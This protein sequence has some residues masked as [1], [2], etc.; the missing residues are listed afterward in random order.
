MISHLYQSLCLL[1]AYSKLLLNSNSHNMKKYFTKLGI[2]VL[3]LLLTSTLAMAQFTVSGTVTN[4]AGEA[5]IGCTVLIKNTVQGTVTDLDGKYTVELPDESATLLF[6]SVGMQSVEQEVTAETTTLDIVLPESNNRLEEVVVSGLATSV[7]RANLANSVASISAKE[8]TGIAPAA[9]T[10]GA[11]YGKFKG[12]V[13]NSNSGAPGGGM[14][15][16]LRG[17]TSIF[18]NAQPLYIVD[19]VYV[20]NSSVSAGLN[21]VSS[22]SGGG[23]QSNQDNPSNR[24]A[25]IDPGDIE[26]IEILKGASAAAMYGS[27][28]AAGVVII[29]TKK[30]KAGQT[31]VKLS[32]SIGVTSQLRKLGIREWDAAEVGEVFGTEDSL[33]FLQG[34][35]NFEDELYGNKGILSDTR[36]SVTGGNEQTSFYAGGSYKNDEGIVK[37]TGYEK[38]SIRL[39]IAHKLTD[40]LKLDATSNYIHSSADRG[41]FNNDNSGTT[42]GVAFVATPQWAQ[43]LP[44]ANGN[45]PNNPYSSSNFLQTRDLITNNE[46]ENRII[47]GATATARLF[48][49]DKQSLQLKLRGG[50]DNYTLRTTAIFPRTLQ[51]FQSEDTDQGHSIQGSTTSNQTNLAAF[52]VHSFFATRGLSFRTQLGVTAENFDL[53]TILVDANNLNG[54]QTNVDQAASQATEQNR[55][56]QK[57]RGFFVQEEV[58]FQDKVIATI[59]L[60]GDKSSNNGDPNKL[61]YYPKAS[62]A[63]NLHEFDFLGDDGLISA[64]KLRTA[65]GQAGNFARFGSKYTSFVGSI[66]IDGNAALPIAR[67]LG[68]E[69]IGPERQTEIEFGADIGLLNDKVFLDATYYI[70]S[71][72]DLLLD[73]AIPTSTGFGFKASNAAEL[74]NRGIELGLSINPIN[75]PNLKWSSKTSFWLNRSEV[76]KLDIPAFNLGAFGAGLGIF[77]VEEGRSATQIVGSCGEC[78]GVTPD[79]N[80]LVVY[81]NAEPDF[82]MSFLNN[83]N[84]L[85]NFDLAFLLHWKQG[86]DNINLSKLLSDLNNTSPDYEDTNLDPTGQMINGDYRVTAFNNGNPSVFVED[87]SY[88]R[89]REVSLFYSLPRTFLGNIANLRVG[90]S[91]NNLLNFFSYNSYDPEVSNFGGNG[92]STGVEVTPFPSAKRWNF[93]ISAEF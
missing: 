71:V 17:V 74:Q 48:S 58:N 40:W 81:G 6:S 1:I 34:T 78:E 28:A 68:N 66:T 42:M 45:Y 8:L 89:L 16:K 15:V 51:F 61:F 63:L 30:G 9:T 54:S 47:T 24:I 90:F 32:Q 60:R 82:Q 84:F 57:D 31:K 79:E 44:D 59:G 20:N 21:S 14:S 35:T 46:K 53:N 13:V 2:A 23:N 10:D 27:R 55:V 93:H 7:K 19:G 91:G 3:L 26:N 77:R 64:L 39:N 5:I 67:L 86:G 85:R 83:I 73:E 12:V 87:A 56:I 22:A 69:N 29:T 50:L 75:N 38:T 18:G 43:L 11:F 72:N 37:N 41:F 92:L 36:L 25:D 76:T 33:L 88:V 49:N 70:K 80:G 65:F 52:L 4:E 62:L